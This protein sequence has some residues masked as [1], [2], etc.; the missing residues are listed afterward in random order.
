MECPKCHAVNVESNKHCCQCGARLD[1]IGIAV[2]AYLDA[3]LRERVQASIKDEF[4]DQKLTEIEI[5]ANVAEKITGWGKMFSLVV[6]IPVTLFL[7]LLGTLGLKE[8]KDFTGKLD[9]VHAEVA[10]KLAEATNQAELMKTR[11]QAA[12]DQSAKDAA[13]MNKRSAELKQRLHEMSAQLDQVPDLSKQVRIVSDQVNRL[14]GS[15]PIS[16]SAEIVGRILKGPGV[17][18]PQGIPEIKRQEGY[19]L[20][21]II[22]HDAAGPDSVEEIL[23]NGRNDLRG[24]LAHWLVKSDGTIS[25]ISPEI[26]TS[27]HLG[28]AK[29]GLKNS[30]T[31]GVEVSG[32]PAFADPRQTEALVRLVVDIAD[33]WQI[34]T[35]KIF[36]HA[37][38]A[39]PPGR[40]SDMLQQAPVVRQMVAAIRNRK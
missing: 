17:L 24:P 12:T 38:V 29:D 28:P 23:K 37:E 32:L 40:K 27:S 35:D 7:V 33:R 31:I 3:S 30:N 5:A 11:V 39:I 15:I 8:Y 6:A 21:A 9:T 18:L 34:P 16:Y 14:T 36:S 26:K 10:S 2:D 1:S 22:L 20:G 25:F 13:E 19:Q 4:K